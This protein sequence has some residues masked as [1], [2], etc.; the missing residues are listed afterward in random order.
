MDG[1]DLIMYVQLPDG[2]MVLSR[3]ALLQAVEVKG[4]IYLQSI[5]MHGHYRP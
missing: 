1:I 3:Q 2:N 4:V 5:G